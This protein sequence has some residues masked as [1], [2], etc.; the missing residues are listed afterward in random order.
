MGFE[1]STGTLLDKV[2]HA[3]LKTAP[4][5]MPKTMTG[6]RNLPGFIETISG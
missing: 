4:K 3:V 2:I 5:V 1:K 6:N